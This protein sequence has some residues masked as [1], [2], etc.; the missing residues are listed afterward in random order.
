MPGTRSGCLFDEGGRGPL[1]PPGEGR[2]PPGRTENPT[3][4]GKILT[5][6]LVILVLAKLVKLILIFEHT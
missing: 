6:L 2:F 5:V 1:G 3:G 4:P